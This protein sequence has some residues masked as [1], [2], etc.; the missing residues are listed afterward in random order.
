MK[1]TDTIAL[2]LV[3]TFDWILTDSF[4]IDLDSSRNVSLFPF[5]LAEFLCYFIPLLVIPKNNKILRTKNLF[6]TAIIGSLIYLIY[7]S[8]WTCFSLFTNESCIMRI[9]L[10]LYPLVVKTI[11]FDILFLGFAFSF[12]FIYKVFSRSELVGDLK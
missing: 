3:V 10:W 9:N 4:N 8:W 6:I 1:I 12:R 5:F 11:I 7:D 2:I